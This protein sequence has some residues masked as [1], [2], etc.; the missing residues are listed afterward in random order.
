[1]RSSPVLTDARFV[2]TESSFF[3]HRGHRLVS[4]PNPEPRMLFWSMMEQVRSCGVIRYQKRWPLLETHLM[5][6]TDVRKEHYLPLR[7]QQV[8]L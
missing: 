5:S 2:P 6:M 7:R 8:G 4:R 3:L 1:M